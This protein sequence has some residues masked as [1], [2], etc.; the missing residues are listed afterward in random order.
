[1]S[2]GF[3]HLA[4]ITET[5]PPEVNGVA[6][7]LQRM[8]VHLRERGYRVTVLRP[9]QTGERAGGDL[10]RALSLPFYPQVRVGYSLP[11]HI[12]QRLRAL[13]PDLVHIATEGPLGL[14]GLRAARHLKIPM[15]SSFHT[16]FD[17]YARHYRLQFLQGLVLRYLRCFHNATR[18][19]LVPS[20][21]TF[22]HLQAQGFLNLAMWRR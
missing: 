18:K 22:A 8:V 20:R 21:G 7:T 11:G 2:E 1:M 19:T 3:A 14:A 9:Q 12:G 10:F 5:Y 17:G 6:H 16:N 4:L 15:V 13:R